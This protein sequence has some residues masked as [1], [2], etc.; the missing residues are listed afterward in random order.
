MK[1]LINKVLDTF[2]NNKEVEQTHVDLNTEDIIKSI[3]DKAYAISDQNVMY[4]SVKEL[5]GYFY[6][7]TIIVGSF[8]I[9]TKIGAKLNVFVD[10]SNLELKPDMNEFESDHSNASNIYMTRI[11]FQIEEED[12]SK[13]K[14]SN[15]NNIQLV[16]KKEILEFALYK[17]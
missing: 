8:K 15:I 14:Q 10:D 11:D 6:F 9:K 1:F 2:N 3:E 13:L 17:A 7:K 5:G 12:V 4:A 16:T